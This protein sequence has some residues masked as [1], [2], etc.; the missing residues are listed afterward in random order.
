MNIYD[1]DKNVRQIICQYQLN[2]EHILMGNGKWKI[3]AFG[4]SLKCF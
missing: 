3:Y 4:L 2:N 1:D